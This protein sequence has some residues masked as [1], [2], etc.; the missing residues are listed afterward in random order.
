MDKSKATTL[1]MAVI[2]ATQLLK[3]HIALEQC[4]GNL[5]D[6][7]TDKEIYELLKWFTVVV[8]ACYLFR[9]LEHTEYIIIKGESN[10]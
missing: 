10:G 9:A 5:S 6:K 4:L 1:T 3:A 2:D 8:G 7:P